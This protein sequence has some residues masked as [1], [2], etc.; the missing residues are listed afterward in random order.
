[1]PPFKP[2]VDTF[3][4]IPIG[5]TDMD[6]DVR[7]LK[8]PGASVVNYDD[9]ISKEEPTTQGKYP[10]PK[11]K[12][13]ERPAVI[14]QPRVVEQPKKVQN[15]M[16][17]DI[18]NSVVNVPPVVQPPQPP[19]QA[20]KQDIFDMGLGGVSFEPTPPPQPKPVNNDPFNILGLEMGGGS[21]PVQTP[22]PNN[23][24]FGGDLLGFGL[25]GP[26]N[27]QPVVAQPPAN[28]LLGGADL[29]GFGFAP[30]PSPPVAVNQGG[31]N[32]G[33][34]TPQPPQPQV[35]NNFGFNLLGGSQ[36]AQQA[37][38]PVSLPAQNTSAFQPIINNNPNKI[39]AYDNSHLQIWID[40]IK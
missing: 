2:T 14:E 33:Q 17:D 28:N 1:V 35:N 40:C 7:T 19:P 9:H 32:F 10:A 26:S 21:A 4:N 11:Q 39:L 13:P 34:P 31:F 25:S 12:E 38:Q 15:I 24:G 8:M 23:G 18:F 30:T 6:L 27:P 16:D 20:P 3:K 29:M 5:E 22:P 37:P 36:S